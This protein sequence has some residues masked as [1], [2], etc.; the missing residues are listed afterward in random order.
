MMVLPLISY[1][2]FL[3]GDLCN[4]FDARGLCAILDIDSVCQVPTYVDNAVADSLA[5]T[6][7]AIQSVINTFSADVDISR[8]FETNVNQSTTVEKI[9]EAIQQELD[10]AYSKIDWVLAISDKLLALTFVWL[11]IKSYMYHSSYRSKDSFDNQYITAQ[12]KILDSSRKERGASHILPLKKH[13]KNHL[14]DATALR[15]S[16]TEKQYLTMG[17]SRVLLHIIIAGI[18]MFMDFGLYWLLSKIQEHG[19]YEVEVSGGTGANVDIGGTGILSEFVRLLFA[20]GFQASTAFNTTLNTTKCLPQPS[21]PNNNLAVAIGFLYATTIIMVLSQAYARRLL[22]YIAA[23]YYPEREL[24]RTK[25]LYGR[26]MQKRQTLK[27]MLRD[28]VKI[29][30]KERDANERISITAYL[31]RNIPCCKSLL[32]CCGFKKLQ[33]LGCRCPDDGFLAY[34]SDTECDGVYCEECARAL[35]GKCTICDDII[36]LGQ[37]PKEAEH[38]F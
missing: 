36:S 19:R 32:S 9:Q 18:L 11:C 1:Y 17:L 4:I 31:A 8:Q 24:E 30:K 38:Q 28:A 26:T 7:R 15:L 20:E 5:G 25:Y 6:R 12:F 21:P 14:I 2:V 22:R 16:R 23:Y 3:V 10:E 29:N 33:C 13:E 27:K 37:K 34:C 35:K